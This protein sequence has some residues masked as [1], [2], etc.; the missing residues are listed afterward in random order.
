MNEPFRDISYY[1]PTV[2]FNE[3][4]LKYQSGYSS[5]N[6]TKLD[7]DKAHG[8]LVRCRENPAPV[9]PIWHLQTH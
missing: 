6:I 3:I 9:T 1:Y 7:H 4:E 2:M 5:G 8:F